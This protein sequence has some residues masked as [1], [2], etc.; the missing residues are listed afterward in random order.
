MPLRLVVMGVSG[1]GK[2]S[3]GMALAQTLGVGFIDADDLHPQ[4]NRQKMASG[5]PLTDAD[6][7]PWLDLVAQCLADQAPVIVACSALRRAYRDRL[8]LAG[9][10]QF[11]H[12]SAPQELIAQ[13]LAQRQ[14]HFM[15]PA[16]LTSQYAALEAPGP[17]EAITLDAALP[18]EMLVTQALQK[19]RR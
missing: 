12:L 5:Q 7:A 13:R 8:R 3:L 1:C 19:L 15:P 9:E 16:L 2:T 4:A 11:L 18:F 17:D 6:R 14:G 10:V